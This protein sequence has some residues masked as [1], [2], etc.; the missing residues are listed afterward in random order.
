MADTTSPTT[1]PANANAP[2]APAASGKVPIAEGKHIF[3]SFVDETGTARVVL[4]DVS[5]AIEEGEVVCIL[6]ESGCGK[7]TLLRILVGLI[8]ATKGEVICHGAPLD[9]IHQGAAIV[10]QSFAL[11]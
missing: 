6:G 5:L 2:A 1:T 8:A 3:K 9:G 4:E 11:Y 7:S 10:F